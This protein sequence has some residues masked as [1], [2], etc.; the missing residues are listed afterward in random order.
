[1]KKI[2]FVCHGN[3]CRSPMAEFIMKEIVRKAQCCTE[4]H[5]ESSA[6]SSEEIGNGIYHPAEYTLSQHG[7]PCS[8]HRARRFTIEGAHVV[9]VLE[10][11]SHYG[12]MARNYHRCIEAFGIPI[13]YRCSISKIHG[14]S[15]ICG[16][17]VL[18]LESGKTNYLPC[19]TL[20]TAIGLIPERGPVRGLGNPEWL[21]FTG[22]CDHVHEMVDSAVSDAAETGR[23][24]AKILTG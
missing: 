13:R 10:K 2:M 14:E 24:L 12:G 3:I 17:T 20:V 5:I 4:V 1:M 21:Y 8:G 9:A 11:E 22:N 6:T 19:Q 18:D 15:R 16:V 23:T 7:I